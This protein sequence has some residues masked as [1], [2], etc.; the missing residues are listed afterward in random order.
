MLP[1]RPLLTRARRV[2]DAADVADLRRLAARRA[3]RMV[4]DYVDGAAEGERSMA[5]AVAAFDRVEFSPRVLRD[6]SEAPTSVEVLGRRIAMPVVL[7]PTGF[8]RMMHREGERAVARAA[9]RAAV[10]YT[11]STMG[12]TS[13]KDVAI[14][15][16]GGWNWFQLY[17]VRDRSRSLDTLALAREAG[18]DVL[19]VTVDVPVAGARLRDVRHG[20]TIPPSLHWRSVLQAVWRPAWWFD[21]L[22]SE[23]LRFATVEGAPGDLAGI[24]NLMFDPSVTIS[25]LAWIRSAWPGR[26][27]VKGVQRVDDAKEL[28]AAG[29]DGLVVSNH[30][31]RQLDRSP[32]PLELLPHVVDAVGD[33]VEVYLD[34][35]V[36]SGA[37]VAA[38]VAFG[39]RACFVGRAYLYG[40][41]AG[42][43]LGVR[44]VLDL[45][46]AELV[47]TLQLLGVGGVAELSRDMVRLR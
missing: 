22:T 33:R 44:R 4:F 31:G 16:P 21:F 11:L 14:A 37:D 20:L 45:L 30:G 27:L 13:A 42:G 5:R 40:L 6:V 3:P 36:R 9:E 24:T 32:T 17:V 28:A 43:E 25:D 8:T 18:M 47:R 26:L 41:M 35:G 39:A 19:V 1:R 12:T 2:A 29:V 46:R 38:A 7:G 15:A 10:P 34:G 23:P